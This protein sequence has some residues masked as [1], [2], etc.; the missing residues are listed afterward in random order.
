MIPLNNKTKYMLH[1]KL[2]STSVYHR[3][4]IGDRDLDQ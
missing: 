4:A 3:E 1:T 2:G